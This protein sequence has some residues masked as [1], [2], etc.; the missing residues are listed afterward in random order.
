MK[1]ILREPISDLGSEGEVV[2]VA[3]GYA[4]NYL[5][6]KGLAYPATE[7]FL[8]QFDEERERVRAKAEQAR[9]AAQEVAERLQGFSVTLP[10]K[11]SEEGTLFGSVSTGDITEK[12]EGEGFP[13]ERKAVRLSQPLKELGIYDV[14]V[15][16]Y[17]GVE[18]EIKVWVV[19][20]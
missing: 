5:L 14:Q 8:R 10:V 17:P 1:I 2:D 20:E 18:A 19:K 7:K 6:P 12:L 15:E 16:L 4:R 11:A 3:L 9:V 13:V